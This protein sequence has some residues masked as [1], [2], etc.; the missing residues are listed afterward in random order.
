MG[1]NV[2]NAENQRVLASVKYGVYMAKKTA[3]KPVKKPAKKK[4]KC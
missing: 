2:K 1:K 3:A 4:G